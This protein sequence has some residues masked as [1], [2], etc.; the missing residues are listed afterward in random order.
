MREFPTLSAKAQALILAS[1][2]RDGSSSEEA[3]RIRADFPMLPL[4]QPK[5]QQEQ[6]SSY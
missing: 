4:D 3:W 5:A 1:L 6:V 2:E